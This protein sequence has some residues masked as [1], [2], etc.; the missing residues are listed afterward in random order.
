MEQVF[1]VQFAGQP[2]RRV[3]LSELIQNYSRDEVVTDWA[4]QANVGGTLTV[5]Q[6]P[7]VTIRRVS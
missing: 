7:R 6:A 2:A 5:G 3:P 1:S 4:Q